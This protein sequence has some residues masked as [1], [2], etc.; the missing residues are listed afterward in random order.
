MQQK[1]NRKTSWAPPSKDPI[2]R[3]VHAVNKGFAAMGWKS[4]WK[5]MGTPIP[6]RHS[7]ATNARGRER[8]ERTHNAPSG[9]SAS[10]ARDPGGRQPPWKKKALVRNQA[11]M[12][13]SDAVYSEVHMSRVQIPPV[14]VV[15]RASAF[16][17]G[18]TKVKHSTL[19]AQAKHKQ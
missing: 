14:P 19:L 4:V 17:A 3:V 1:C 5:A 12:V 8:S 10:E 13:Y 6:P 9:A 7:R 15:P 2:G 16:S 18:T 11:P